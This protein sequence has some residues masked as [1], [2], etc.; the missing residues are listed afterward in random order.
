MFNERRAAIPRGTRVPQL[1]SAVFE[2]SDGSDGHA[3]MY[4][5]TLSV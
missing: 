1:R 3:G 2:V 4:G 5:G